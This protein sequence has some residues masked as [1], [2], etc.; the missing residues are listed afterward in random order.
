[1]NETLEKL[2]CMLKTTG[3]V[4]FLRINLKLTLG[5]F[6]FEWLCDYD[7]GLLVKE[8]NPNILLHPAVSKI[9]VIIIK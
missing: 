6:S 5:T 3:E 8:M 4:G 2:P 9:H 7:V 1:M